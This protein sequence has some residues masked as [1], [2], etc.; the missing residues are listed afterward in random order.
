M[1]ISN[2]QETM[3]LA[4]KEEE[5]EDDLDFSIDDETTAA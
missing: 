4:A 5:E 3:R 2:L 1:R